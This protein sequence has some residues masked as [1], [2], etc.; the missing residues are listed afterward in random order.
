MAIRPESTSSANKIFCWVGRLIG[1][2]TGPP[3]KNSKIKT[4]II[5]QSILIFLSIIPDEKEMYSAYIT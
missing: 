5:P 1:S 4:V 2:D 3:H